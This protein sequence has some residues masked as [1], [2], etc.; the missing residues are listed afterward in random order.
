MDHYFNQLTLHK[1]YLNLSWNYLI[2]Y[3]SVN[4]IFKKAF[5]CNMLWK[6]QLNQYHEDIDVD[7]FINV[8]ATDNYKII[9]QK[10]EDISFIIK[11]LNLLE[12]KNELIVSNLLHLGGKHLRIIPK[13]INSLIS[14]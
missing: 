9:F 12:S 2:N 10:C 8:Y 6:H 5:D 11:S 13:E 7:I 14:L 3:N 4:K 1:I